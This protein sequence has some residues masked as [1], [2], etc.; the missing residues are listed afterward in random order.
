MAKAMLNKTLMPV[1]EK[2]EI[3]ENKDLH[4][5]GANWLDD[6]SGTVLYSVVHVCVLIEIDV[7]MLRQ[8]TACPP[9]VPCHDPE[10]A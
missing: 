1:V 9:I 4:D 5:V 8:G 3:L 2:F 6:G 7:L 10:L